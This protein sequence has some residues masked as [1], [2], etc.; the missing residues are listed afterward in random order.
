M[1]RL[2]GLARQQ[3]VSWQSEDVDADGGKA[4]VGI[5]HD[6]ARLFVA[7]PEANAEFVAAACDAAGGIARLIERGALEA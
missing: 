5:S 3:R 2:A 7:L 6:R 1:A 4:D